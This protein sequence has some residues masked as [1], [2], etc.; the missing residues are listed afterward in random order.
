MWSSQTSHGKRIP[1]AMLHT[2]T[3]SALVTAY[4]ET[5][6]KGRPSYDPMRRVASHWIITLTATPTRSEVLARH[7]AKCPGHFQPGATTAN[8]ELALMRAACRWGLY[9]ECWDGGDPTAGVKKWKTPKRKRIGRYQELRAILL[10]FDRATT[11][12][13]IRDRA[14]FGLQ[15]FTGCRS[16]EARTARLNA[17]QPYGSMGCWMKPTTKTGQPHEVP[18]P[19]QMMVWLQDWLTIRPM[20]EHLKGANPYLFPGQWYGQ[21]MTPNGVRAQW[22]DIRSALQMHGLWAYD[23]RR[24]IACYLSNEL[25]ADDKTIQAILNHY[26]GRA[27]SHYVHKTFDSLTGV[28]QGYA[29]WLWALKGKE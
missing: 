16:I 9:Q 15:L 5:Q 2:T 17:I 23:L 12:T 1:R 26:D 14:L 29:D 10:Y 28:I 6:L 3:F 27:L 4:L 25:H 21:P 20:V 18:V 8:T 7:R 24:T 11:P 22:A 13:E 19:T